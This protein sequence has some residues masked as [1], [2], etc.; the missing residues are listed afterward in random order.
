MVSAADRVK[1]ADKLETMLSTM[2]APKD[3]TGR[4]AS[5]LERDGLLRHNAR[6]D[7]HGFAQDVVLNNHDLDLDELKVENALA[8]DDP[9]ELIDRLR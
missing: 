9:E 6:L 3:L 4:I 1:I 7:P 2:D 5:D 8:A